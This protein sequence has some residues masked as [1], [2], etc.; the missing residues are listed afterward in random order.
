MIA[1][2]FSVMCGL[3]W[4]ACVREK[5]EEA[6]LSRG[7]GGGQGDVV[8][9]KEGGE[10]KEEALLWRGRRRRGGSGGLHLGRLWN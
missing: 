2:L 10:K 1:C 4:R 7:K 5:G 8:V 6:L 9:K 3:L